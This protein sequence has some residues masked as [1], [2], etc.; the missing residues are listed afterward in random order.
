MK[1]QTFAPSTCSCRST[2]SLPMAPVC[3]LRD[4]L[5]KRR[6]NARR[7]R[8]W[9]RGAGVVVRFFFLFFFLSPRLPRRA[10]PRLSRELSPLNPS[11]RRRGWCHPRKEITQEQIR[12]TIQS[13]LERRSLGKVQHVQPDAGSIPHPW[14]EEVKTYSGFFFPILIWSNLNKKESCQIRETVSTN[15]L[16]LFRKK[17]YQGNFLSSKWI[18]LRAVYSNLFPVLLILELIKNGLLYDISDEPT[19]CVE[20]AMQFLDL[21]TFSATAASWRNIPMFVE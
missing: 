10:P 13:A 15:I 4:E 6:R 16:M 5:I 7:R 3:H 8:Y 11:E 12:L 9:N 18:M 1:A 2:P 14:H 17:A 21:P 19:Q 20:W